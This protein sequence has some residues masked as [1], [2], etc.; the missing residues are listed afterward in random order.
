MATVHEGRESNHVVEARQTVVPGGREAVERA[1][2]ASACGREIDTSFVERRHATDRGRD[3]RKSRR[4]Y[5]FSKDWRVQEAMT[6]STPYRDNFCWTVRTLRV[7]GA[8][9]RWRQR[10]PAMAA[11][12]A[13]YRW[14]PGEWF[15]FP[16]IQS[17]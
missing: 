1:L 4:T 5:R 8:G 11:G 13:D 12:L 17:R 2:E 9:G 14:S 7:K 10:T 15:S 3:A 6:Y 16:A